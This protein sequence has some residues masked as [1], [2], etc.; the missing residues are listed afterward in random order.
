MPRPCAPPPELVWELDPPEIPK[1]LFSLWHRFQD[2]ELSRHGLETQVKGQG[3]KLIR[4][5]VPTAEQLPTQARRLVQGLDRAL[6]RL[7]V[8]TEVEGVE[9]TNNVAERDLRRGVMWR[10]KTQATRTERGR[11]FAERLMTV[12]VSCRAQ[13]RSTFDF[14]CDT[15]LPDTPSPS[16]LPST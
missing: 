6:E 13:A 10:K 2:G 16:L 15:L 8:F 4:S 5:L 11:R 12:V 9:P 3:R 14:L 1:P 7:F